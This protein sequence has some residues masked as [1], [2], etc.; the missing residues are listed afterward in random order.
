MQKKLSLKIVLDLNIRV[1]LGCI[2][3]IHHGGYRLE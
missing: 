1:S 3:E 2:E